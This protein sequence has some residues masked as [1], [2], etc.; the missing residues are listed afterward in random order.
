MAF[1]GK[2]ERLQALHE[3]LR[4]GRPRPDS[5]AA[6]FCASAL[7]PGDGEPGALAAAVSERFGAIREQVGRHTAP[8]GGLRWTYA[9]LLVRSGV[10]VERFVALRDALRESRAASKTGGLGAGGARAALVLCAGDLTPDEAAQRF[11]AMKQALNPPWWRRDAAVTDMFAAAHAVRG[12]DP[13]SIVQ[14]RTRAEAVF[15][16][17]RRTS[18][19]K[20]TGGRACALFE[21][22]PRTVLRT[23]ER[24]DDVRKRERILRH[25]VTRSM[26]LEWTAQGL[27]EG[28]LDDVAQIL[29]KLPSRCSVPGAGRAQLAHLVHTSD[30]ASLV[31][32]EVSALAA[33]IAAQTAAIMA[34]TTAATV[35]TTSAGN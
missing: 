19:H 2:L 8:T 26:L 18:G 9:S 35:A 5:I 15:A 12:D 27:N 22:E 28:G 7:L 6:W 32:G 24:L 1:N 25:R 30:Q 16:E 34:A 33:V 17:D 10:Q 3:A 31:A 11:F 29:E 14:A 21:A 4:D 23:F 13:R 20:R